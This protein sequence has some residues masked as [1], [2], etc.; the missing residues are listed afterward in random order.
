[1]SYV[2]H[3]LT[4]KSISYGRTRSASSIK[5][6]VLHYTGNKTDTAKG[7]ANYFSPNGSN[8][9]AAGAHYFVD[10][11]TVYQSIP[12]TRVAWSVGGSKYSDCARTSGGKMYGMI[13]NSNSVS[14]EMCSK[15]GKITDATIANA[16][17]LAK[18]LMARYGIPASRVY[19][20]FDVNGKQCPGWNGWTSKS[21][22]LWDAF[23]KALTT[24][25]SSTSNAKKEDEDDMMYYKKFENIPSYYQKAVKKL[26]DKGAIAGTGG[27][28]LN[29]SEDLCR[30]LTILDNAGV[31]DG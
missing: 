2:F 3:T 1:M 17:A 15:N 27:G 22:P 28:E 31:F 20:H 13:T 26:I 29:V 21:A 12:D 8:T 14:I 23:K 11:T 16:V 30:I 4:A 18:V 19:R 25:A 24:N 9:R 7:N 10:D 6:I 5:Y